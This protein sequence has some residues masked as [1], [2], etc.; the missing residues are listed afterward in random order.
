MESVR[1]LLPPLRSTVTSVAE[2]SSSL[3]SSKGGWDLGEELTAVMAGGCN[4]QG[5]EMMA[6]SGVHFGTDWGASTD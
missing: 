6:S 4:F 5:S 1:F 3:F 2:K